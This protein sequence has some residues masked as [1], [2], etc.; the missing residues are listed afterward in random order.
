MENCLQNDKHLRKQKS[1]LAEH[2][3]E[4]SF[5]KLVYNFS[6]DRHDRGVNSLKTKQR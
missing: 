6:L 4:A 3:G 5:S 2:F 1:C